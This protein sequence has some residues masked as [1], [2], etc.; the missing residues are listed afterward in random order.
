MKCLNEN[1]LNATEAGLFESLY[2]ACTDNSLNLNDKERYVL[3]SLPTLYIVE[4]ALQV[5]KCKAAAGYLSAILALFM[6]TK[7]FPIDF[8]N[9]YSL[10]LGRQ[11]QG[12]TA[13]KN[14][15]VCMVDKSKVVPTK[16]GLTPQ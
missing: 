11:S 12:V 10:T 3:T 9:E 15:M 1:L 5:F 13:F 8:F 14:A 16:P 4:N 7:E 6:E 2:Q